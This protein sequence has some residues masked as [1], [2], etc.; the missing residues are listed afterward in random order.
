[1][2]YKYVI[3]KMHLLLYESLRRVINCCLQLTNERVPAKCKVNVITFFAECSFCTPVTSS[4]DYLLLRPSNALPHN[5]L[6]SSSQCTLNVVQIPG[7]EYYNLRHLC[8]GVHPRHLC[9]GVLERCICSREVGTELYNQ[10]NTRH[11]RSDS[12]KAQKILVEVLGV[13]TGIRTWYSTPILQAILPE[14]IF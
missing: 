7:K 8:I 10:T 12:G 2:K 11:L 1:M 4:A 14:S 6:I 5:A 13:P 3:D 9:F